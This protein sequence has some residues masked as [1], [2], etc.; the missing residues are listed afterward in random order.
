MDHIYDLEHPADIEIC[1]NGDLYACTGILMT[2]G[3]RSRIRSVLGVP[4]T[5]QSL[6]T[7][8][9]RQLLHFNYGIKFTK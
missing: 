1:I 5:F 9:V 6:T 2:I 3:D 4:G 7:N 8:S